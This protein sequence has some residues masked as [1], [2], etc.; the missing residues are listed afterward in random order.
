LLVL[1]ATSFF[2]ARSIRQSSTSIQS[3][4]RTDAID[5]NQLLAA[6]A[7]RTLESE[8]E[9]Y[10]RLTS[11]EA[12]R[13]KFVDQLNKTL[14]TAE[15]AQSLGE[16]AAMNTPLATHDSTDARER[17]LD[18]PARKELLAILDK[19][20]DR[21][22]ST[23]H[24]SRR[25]RLATMFVTDASG[26]II[27]IAYD[28][29]IERDENS[30]GKNYCYR[31]YFHGGRVDL[32]K[33]TTEIDQVEA[34][35][36]THHLSAAFQSTA[37]RLW[38]V[39]VSTPIYLTEDRSKPDAMFVVTINLGDFELPQSKQG[40]NQIAVLVEAREGPAQG[41]ILQHPLMDSRRRAGVRMEG[42]KYQMSASLMQDLLEGGD[43]DYLDPLAEASDGSPYAGDWV[44][45]MQSVTLPQDQ[46]EI[47]GDLQN[48]AKDNT[49]LLVLAQ[50]RLETVF[51]PV[52]R[53]TSQLLRGGAAAITSILVVTLTLWLFVR[54]VG[55][56]TSREQASE[57]NPE[58]RG[59]TETIPAR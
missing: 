20:L 42:E 36:S 37:T 8:I 21:F 18:N 9:R 41:T 50:Y 29:K 45:A 11:E 56:S 40:A 47:D 14:N 34:L 16:I 30:A 44:A 35:T 46:S 23:D 31:T 7:A 53:M 54:K 57:D 33:E 59:T 24:R 28:E 12:S 3:E 13:P 22:T 2:G 32:P 51:E 10:F 58:H 48:Q 26:T 38:K 1:L 27:S 49:D 5:S 52:E 15:V 25:P 43:V 4:L 6:F 55:S 17:L 39:A 19:R